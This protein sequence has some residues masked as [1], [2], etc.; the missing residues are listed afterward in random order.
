[1]TIEIG[2]NSLHDLRDAPMIKSFVDR[3]ATL[4]GEK[5]ALA[6]DI[7]SVYGEAKEK[8]LDVKA[9]RV[10]VK[11][12]REDA[13]KRAAREAHEAAIDALMAML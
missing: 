2:H 5:A 1:M 13:D 6:E 9:L 10:V 11:R 3:I 12:A 7:R 8:Q 4:E